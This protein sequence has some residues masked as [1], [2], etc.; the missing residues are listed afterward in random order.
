MPLGSTARTDGRLRHHPDEVEE[1]H[2]V[3]LEE[4]RAA[5]AAAPWALSPW[6][7]EQAVELE[8]AGFFAA[9]AGVAT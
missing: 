9:P 4:L 7:R 5:L 6:L 3:T 1:S 2:W 8:A